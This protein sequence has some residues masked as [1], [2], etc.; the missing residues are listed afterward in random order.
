MS[1][2]NHTK[3]QNR[4]N[5]EMN[6]ALRGDHSYETQCFCKRCDSIAGLYKIRQNNLDVIVEKYKDTCV[7]KENQFGE[8]VHDSDACRDSVQTLCSEKRQYFNSWL[9]FL[10][11]YDVEAFAWKRLASRIANNKLMIDMSDIE[12]CERAVGREV[13]KLHDLRDALNQSPYL[14]S[15]SKQSIDYVETSPFSALKLLIQFK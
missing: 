7:M 8:L 2:T 6:N 14:K 4:E 12:E 10:I 1:G 3:V 5:K 13:A 9:L 11:N 15:Y